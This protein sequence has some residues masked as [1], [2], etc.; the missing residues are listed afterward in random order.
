MKFNSQCIQQV[1]NE[2]YTIFIS[3]E[4]SITKQ[5]KMLKQLINFYSELMCANDRYNTFMPVIYYCTRNS[6]LFNNHEGRM[7]R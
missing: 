2:Y 1:I 6:E 7:H 3:T 5:L 4:S